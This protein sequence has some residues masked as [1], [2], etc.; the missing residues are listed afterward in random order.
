MCALLKTTKVAILFELHD[1]QWFSTQ[2]AFCTASKFASKYSLGLFKGQQTASQLWFREAQINAAA[3]RDNQFPSFCP[4]QSL[5]LPSYHFSPK[6]AVTTIHN[7]QGT[8]I[9]LSA[10][11]LKDQF[12]TL[13]K[14]YLKSSKYVKITCISAGQTD[15]YL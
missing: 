10:S 15:T 6:Q 7:I 5:Y 14:S 1:F 8:T 2:Q 11:F 4:L 3:N 13:T 12:G 9:Q